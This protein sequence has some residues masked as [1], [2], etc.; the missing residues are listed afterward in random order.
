VNEQQTVK[1]SKFLSL[2]LRH[3]PEEIGITLDDAGWVNVDVL[4]TAM[5]AHDRPITEA[6]LRHVV[7]TSDKKRFALSDDGRRIRASQ[8]HSVEVELGYEPA[9]PPDVLFHGTV[10]RFLDS[11]RA[12]G[13]A[14]GRRHHVHLTADVATAATVG[15][16]RG[17]A[18]VLTIDAAAMAREGLTFYVSANGVWLTDHVPARFIAL[19]GARLT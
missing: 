11:I 2:V 12:G 10:E 13:L 16:R 15:G 5:A 4:L 19:D 6:D 18:V 14:K 7:D 3:K 1:I 17:R 9:T 8:G